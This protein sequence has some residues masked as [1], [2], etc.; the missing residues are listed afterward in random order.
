[1]GIIER[2]ILESALLQKPAV[3]WWIAFILMTSGLGTLD[4]S[5]PGQSLPNASAQSANRLAPETRA[6]QI[7]IER[8]QKAA[9]LRP[10][11]NSRAEHVLQT[12]EEDKI[13]ERVFGGISGWRLKLGG[14][15]VRSGFA[16]GPEYVRHFDNGQM[17][18]YASIRAS[19]RHYYLMETGLNMPHLAF[20]HIFANLYAV[21]YDYPSVEYY[22][23]VRIRT[24]PAAA[25][26]CSRTLPFRDVSACSRFMA[27][28]VSAPWAPTR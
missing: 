20:D 18:F 17:R 11:E 22:G 24:R 28:C 8:E 6:G 9:D 3:G 4:L 27:G 15:I 12:V 14:M 25:T 7:E 26:T 23:P 16:A 1:L 19:P 2:F 21:H 5:A 13:I 10:E